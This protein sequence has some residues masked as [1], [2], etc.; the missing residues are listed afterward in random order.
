MAGLAQASEVVEVVGA[1]V[2][3]REDVMDFLHWCV[4]GLGCVS[5][6]AQC[7]CEEPVT[8]VPVERLWTGKRP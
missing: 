1:A 3:E 4:E 6:G 2:F 5:V 8:R 7:V